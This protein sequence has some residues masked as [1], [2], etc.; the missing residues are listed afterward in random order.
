MS[1]D[2]LYH[3]NGYRTLPAL[4]TVCTSSYPYDLYN[5]VIEFR[6]SNLNYILIMKKITIYIFPDAF[7]FTFFD[8]Y[9]CNIF[10]ISIS[11]TLTSWTSQ[12]GATVSRIRHIITDP[13]T[14]GLTL[15]K[16]YFSH[17][18][19]KITTVAIYCVVTISIK[20]ICPVYCWWSYEK[21]NCLYLHYVVVFEWIF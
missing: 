20:K 13:N 8:F 21:L 4:Y 12:A 11:P 17:R 7:V 10:P 19:C 16:T 6:L 15:C 18:Q 2:I 5:L 9:V 14:Q 1:F 3:N